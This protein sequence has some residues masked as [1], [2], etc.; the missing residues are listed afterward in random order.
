M[1][2]KI[3]AMY[4]ENR[5]NEAAYDAAEAANDQ[6]KMEAE[7]TRHHELCLEARDNGKDFCFMLRLYTSMKERG[8]VVIDLNDVHENQVEEVAGILL[9]FGVKKFTFSSTWSSAISAAWE[10]CQHGF[11]MGGMIQINSECQDFRTG[12]WKKAPAIVFTVNE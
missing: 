11:T 1:M 6:D 2:E 8:N 4:E 12:E 3:I 9:K 5:K 7:R 10:F